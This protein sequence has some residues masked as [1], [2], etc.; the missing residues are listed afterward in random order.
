MGKDTEWKSF[1]QDSQRYADIINGIGCD[2]VQLVKGSDLQEADT[3]SRRKSRDLLRK[4]ALGINF[5]IVG[6]EN[7]DERDYGLPLRNMHYDVSCYQKQASVIRKEVR[8]KPQGLESGEYLYG[9]KKDSRLNPLIT[10]VL[11]AGKEP[12]DGP[13]CL[14]DILDFTDIPDKL[15]GMASDYKINIIDIH[16]F[17]HTEVFRTDVKQVF[18]FIRC[19]DDKRKLL[20]LVEGD[21]YYRQMEED[22]FEVV[23]KYTNSKEIVQMKEYKA[24]GGR[25]D[26]CKAIRDL[27]DDS[28]EEGREEGRQEGREEGRQEGRE[29]GRQEGREEG[30]QEGKELAKL[31]IAKGLLDILA[32][33]VIAEK[34]ELPLR[35]VQE[36][37]MQTFS[38][39]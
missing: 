37:R 16:R 29:E 3:A 9:F 24:E 32:D 28:R 14:H 27:M 6:I 39:S 12:W 1:F 35:T 17:M 26:M 4:V 34:T 36:L 30:R 18:D 31:R 22:A 20:E 25:K 23:T 38:I 8:A 13:F 33:E 7:Q 11:Y 19:S 5:A 15:K 2:G 10:F 21:V